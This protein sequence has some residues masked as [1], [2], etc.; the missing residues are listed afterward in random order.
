MAGHC[1]EEMQ[2]FIAEGEVAIKYSEKFREYGI[3][4][5]D[6]GS[7]IQEIEF[8]PWCGHKLPGSLRDAWF[9]IVFDELGFE[10]TDDPGIPEE[11]KSSQ[12]WINRKDFA[13]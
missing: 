8:C 6:G 1:C 9:D 11:M 10:D 12:W 5:L 2:I 3:L 7:A 4:V 13:K